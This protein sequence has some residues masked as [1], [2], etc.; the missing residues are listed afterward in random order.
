VALLL[1]AAAMPALAQYEVLPGDP[2]AEKAAFAYENQELRVAVWLDKDL[3]EVYRKGDD[4]GVWFQTNDDAYAVVYRVDTEG[5]V[6][7]LWPRSPLDD[8]FV[9]GG[10][11]YGLPVTGGRRLR[12]STAEGEGF[13]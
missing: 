1:A 11:E 5:L 2:Q 13:V 12:V 9:F 3:D 6:T 8:G 7:V 10:H 4:L